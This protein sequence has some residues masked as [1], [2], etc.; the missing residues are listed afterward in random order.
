MWRFGYKTPP[1]YDD[2]Q[3]FCGGVGVQYGRNGGKCGVCGDPWDGPLEN[4]AGGKYATGIIVRKY[5]VGQVIDVK[6]ELTANHKGY[7]EF[8]ICPSDNPFNKVTHECLEKYPLLLDDTGEER[9]MVPDAGYSQDI[10]VKLRLP[11]GMK[12]I[13]CVLQWKYN[14]ANSWGT[15]K[16]GKGC[17]GCGNQEQFCGCADVTVGHNEVPLN[18]TISKDLL[19]TISKENNE[20]AQRGGKEDNEYAQQ[21]GNPGI[22]A[23]RTTQLQIYSFWFLCI[24]TIRP[25]I[26]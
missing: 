20:Q 10:N 4:E 26:I 22:G 15:S 19:N 8:H 6:V 23:N 3:L 13:A 12:C 2:N 1:N 17:I 14:G 24:A 16:D 11:K 9:Y 18:R 25:F 7:F 5:K 21:G